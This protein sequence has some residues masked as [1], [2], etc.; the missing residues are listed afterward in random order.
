LRYI[1]LNLLLSL[2]L[3]AEIT[4]MKTFEA[5]FTQDVTNDKGNVLSYK[6]HVVASKPQYALWKYN[7]PNNK[8]IYINANKAIIVEPEIEQAIIKKI[9][10]D[11]DFFKIIKNATKVQENI[12]IAEFQNTS[13]TIVLKNSNISSISY[14]NELDNKITIKFSN[15]KKNNVIDFTIFNAK[16]PSDY[17]IIRG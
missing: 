16:I 3:F 2:S 14:K 10:G 1:I 6:G 17:D 9:N 5:D 8:Q 15:Q 7:A 11:F 13:Y 12:Y 4:T